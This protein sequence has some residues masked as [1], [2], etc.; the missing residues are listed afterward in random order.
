M[1][2]G[3][4]QGAEQR[5][6]GRGR[7][8]GAGICGMRG[9]GLEPIGLSFDGLVLESVLKKFTLKTLKPS[10]AGGPWVAP[11]WGPAATMCM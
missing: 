6:R 10:R 11:R 7:V 5:W 8:W 1:V 2:K 3:R 9:E 4:V